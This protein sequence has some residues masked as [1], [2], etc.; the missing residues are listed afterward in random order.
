MTRK[1]ET[2]EDPFP[3][4]CHRSIFPMLF[5]ISLSVVRRSTLGT[6]PGFQLPD[7]RLTFSP[8]ASR[9]L[10]LP[11]T[12]TPDFA[13]PGE[14]DPTA[15]RC[16]S[17]DARTPRTRLRVDRRRSAAQSYFFPPSSTSRKSNFR[18]TERAELSFELSIYRR[19]VTRLYEEKGITRRSI[20]NEFMCNIQFQ[21]CM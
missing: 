10:T 13:S 21:D 16:L 4:S 9:F 3:F 5:S 7:S 18:F 15:S 8:L 17:A 12:P 1:R 20:Y 2:S 19:N 14:P 6:F 11:A